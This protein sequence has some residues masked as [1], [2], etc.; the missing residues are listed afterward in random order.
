MTAPSTSTMHVQDDSGDTR[1][2][3]NADN[4]GEV[5]IAKKAFDALKEKRYLIYRT[6]ADGSQGEL[7]RTWD[8]HA[9]RVV[10]SPQLQGG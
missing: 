2:E 4:A 6:R 10:A 3:W 5:E 7:M 8:P 1:V 9:E